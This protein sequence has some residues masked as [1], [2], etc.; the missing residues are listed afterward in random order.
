MK[1]NDLNNATKPEII[2]D[3]TGRAV[4]VNENA[5]QAFN[6]KT[7]D[8]ISSIIDMNHIKKMS[9]YSDFVD[10]LQTHHPT[11]KEATVT[12][13]DNV[14]SKTLRLTFNKGYDKTNADIRKENDILSV[15]NN[16]K[17]YSS[18]CEISLKNFAQGIKENASESH[19][20]LNLFYD[21]DSFYYNKS[22]LQSLALCS[23]GML[24]EINSSR[25]IDFYL[26]KRGDDLEMKIIVRVTENSEARGIQEIE[27]ICPWIGLRLTLID[28]IC[29]KNEIL[30]TAN[31]IEKSLKITFKVTK[32]KNKKAELSSNL[33]EAQWDELP[34]LLS[35]RP[36]RDISTAEQEGL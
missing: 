9:M 26:K 17:L 1:I 2:V 12:V 14:V 6:I 4:Y 36:M 7:G 20:F 32:L 16:I 21:D 23:I 13:F 35:P 18:K 22:V 31:I 28:N 30:Y 10:V 19:I 15:I 24:N 5:K 8:F 33:F 11:Y 34:N 29:E 27:E 25:P 3:V